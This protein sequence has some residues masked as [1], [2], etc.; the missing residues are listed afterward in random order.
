MSDEP[1]ELTPDP[2]FEVPADR[3]TI[4]ELDDALT[5]TDDLWGDRLAL[6]L[7]APVDLAERT[8]EDVREA[9]LTRSV[10]AAGGDLLSLGWNTMRVIFGDPAPDRRDSSRTG[11]PS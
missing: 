4:H 1:Q 6:I 10:M 11:D 8:K 3:G 7:E 2:Q 5:A 9:L